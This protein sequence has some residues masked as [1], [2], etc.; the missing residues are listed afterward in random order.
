MVARRLPPALLALKGVI[1][2]AVWAP[3]AAKVAERGAEDRWSRGGVPGFQARVS[4]DPGLKVRH[5][6]KPGEN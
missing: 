5:L 4:S 6:S 3:A 1:P 2:P